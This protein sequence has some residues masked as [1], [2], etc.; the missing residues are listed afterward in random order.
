MWMWVQMLSL[1]LGLGG[2]AMGSLRVREGDI[3]WLEEIGALRVMI[4][5]LLLLLVCMRSVL[6]MV[7][8]LG[9]GMLA[10]RRAER[11]WCIQSHGRMM[12]GSVWVSI[13]E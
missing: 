2:R 9:I 8:V 7:V 11:K 10:L 5:N 1:E 13:G 4:L 12:G 3:S 6:I